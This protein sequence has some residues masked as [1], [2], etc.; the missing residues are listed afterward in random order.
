MRLKKLTVTNFR[1]YKEKT[2]IGIDNLTVF[3]GKNDAGKSSLLDALDIFFN[4]VPDA[5]DGCVFC[6]EEELNNVRIACAFDQLPQDIV[7]DAQ[8][9]TD[10]KS[11]YFLNSDGLFEIE[12]VYNCN[13]SGKVKSPSVY[14]HCAHPTASD[15]SDLLVLTNSKLK[16]RARKLGVDLSGINQTINSELRKAIWQN[17]SD[18]MLKESEVELKTETAGKIWEQIEKQLPVYAVFKSDRPS[19]DQDSEAQDPMKSAIKEAIKT[20]EKSLEDI[21]TIVTRQVQ[22]IADKTVEKIREMD[23]EL[24]KQ[25]TPRVTTKNWDSLFNVSLTADNQIPINKRGSGTRRLV[26]LNFFRAKAEQAATEKS[27]GIIFGVEEPETSQHPSNQK[28]LIEAF[29]DLSESENCTVILTTHN[30]LLARRMPQTALRYVKQ[31]ENKSIVSQIKSE[32]DLEE[33]VKSLGVLPDHEVKA[34]L[35]VEGRHDINFLKSISKILAENGEDIENL[36]K[37]EATGKLIFLP[38]GGSSLDL[39]IN[40]MKGFSRRCFYLMDRD[41]KPP[42]K[43]KYADQADEFNKQ[44]NAI[45]WTTT[46]KELENYLHPDA[47]KKILPSYSGTGDPFEDVPR[48]F[49]K[50][51]YES[52]NSPKTWTEVESNKEDLKNKESSAKKRLSIEVVQS[53]SPSLLSKIDQDNDIRK[54]LGEIS[55]ELR[56]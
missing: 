28:M 45:A 33:I 7:I 29:R 2:T 17:A 14:A 37:A 20:Q 30:P 15:Y 41:T 43:P 26:L 52:S 8:Y 53:M 34:F 25:L 46:K 40:R 38:M 50:A 55:R 47:I 4:R 27:A 51:V 5:D 42:A 54:W 31:K 24:A 13:V 22:L 19:T 12:K 9:K 10:L 35:G 48:L 1:S 39:W 21:S 3:I 6:N 32:A 44:P 11:E 23:P 16:E 18:L 56:R 49:A 36:E